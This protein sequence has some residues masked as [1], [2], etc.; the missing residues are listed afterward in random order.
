VINQP[1]TAAE[2]SA[3]HDRMVHLS[4]R[5]VQAYLAGPDVFLPDPATQA[6]AKAKICARY[7]LV[8]RPPLHPEIEKVM[9]L[10][11]ADSWREIYRFDVAMMQECDI[12]IANL[13]PFR[14]AS[15]DAGT[16]VELGW[17]LGAGKKVFGYSNS[18][19][20]FMARSQA[21]V[22]AVGDAMPGLAIEGFG[23]A[24][25]LMVPGAV[26]YGGGLP[27]TL[28]PDGVDRAFD[29]LDVFELCVA[30]IAAHLGVLAPAPL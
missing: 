17:F 9:R 18:A 19:T 24:D 30:E 11:G 13:T 20:G 22:A 12:I 14:G 1:M 4:P 6:R 27:L 28:P 15:A 8:G 7:G 5:P 3:K 29:A 26:E 25:N 16:L 2:N 10:P 21:Q 23:L